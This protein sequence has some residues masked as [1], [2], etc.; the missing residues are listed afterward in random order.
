MKNFVPLMGQSYTSKRNYDLGT[1]NHNFVS[2]LSPYVRRRLITEQEVVQAASQAHGLEGAEKFIQEV[3]WRSYFKGWLE[4]RPGIWNSYVQGV[5]E[6]LEVVN[7]DPNM[8]ARLA[9][10]ESGET[11]ITCFDAGLMN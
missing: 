10:A 2:Q 3:F 4:R 8:E 9:R 7:S 5:H 6:D 1:G 11:G